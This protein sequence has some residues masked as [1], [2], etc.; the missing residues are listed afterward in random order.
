MKEH[1]L[2]QHSFTCEGTYCELNPE[3][4]L[5]FVK[6]N[7]ILITYY[8]C[9]HNGGKYYWKKELVEAVIKNSK[10]YSLSFVSTGVNLERDLRNFRLH[11]ESLKKH[12][13]EVNFIYSDNAGKRYAITNKVDYLEFIANQSELEGNYQMAKEFLSE[14]RYKWLLPQ[15]DELMQY[16]SVYGDSTAEEF[17]TVDYLIKSI[18]NLIKSK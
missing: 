3:R 17:K 13:Q 12:Y 4:F 14:K 1:F 7:F 8:G 16:N 6:N 18:H 2:S 5:F 15:L 11:N 9:M 10:A